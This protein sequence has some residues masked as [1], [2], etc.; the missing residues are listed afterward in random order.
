[1][2]KFEQ[3]QSE[4]NVASFSAG[5][6]ARLA[7]LN[8]TFRRSRDRVAEG[9]ERLSRLGSANTVAKGVELS[10]ESLNRLQGEWPSGLRLRVFGRLLVLLHRKAEAPARSL[11][12]TLTLEVLGANDKVTETVLVQLVQ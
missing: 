7:Y 3:R 9:L 2:W 10:R 5:S 1:M 6:I 12:T 8:G 11:V 4:M